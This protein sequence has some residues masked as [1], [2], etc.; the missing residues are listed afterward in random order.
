MRHVSVGSGLGAILLALALVLSGCATRLPASD[1]AVA[2]RAP[3]DAFALEGRLS[4]SDSTR[5]ASGR[6]HWSHAAE[7]DEWTFFNPLGQ[8]VAQLVSTPAGA[9]LRTADGQHVRAP[10]ADRLLPELLGV[11]APVAALP[12]WVQ[13]VP[14]DGARVLQSDEYGRPLRISDA[15]WIIDYLEYADPAPQAPP[16]RLEARW[17]EARL[18][19]ILDEWLERP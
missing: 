5:A 14:R 15:G 16:R 6:M 17:G 11:S 12:Y 13:A 10:D 3:A 19:L 8:I 9:E 18:R 4:A 7:R 1:P 2:A